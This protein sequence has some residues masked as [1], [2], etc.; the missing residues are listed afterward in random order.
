[1]QSQLCTI[2]KSITLIIAPF[3]LGEIHIALGVVG[4]LLNII[5][6]ARSLRK[7]KKDYEK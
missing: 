1:M 5:Y 6:M 3:G 7:Q 2:A 4:S